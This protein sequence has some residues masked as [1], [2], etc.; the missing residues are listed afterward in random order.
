VAWLAVGAAWTGFAAAAPTPAPADA[1]VVRTSANYRVPA[2]PLVRADGAAVTLASELDYPGA[3]AL[4]FVFTSCSAICPIQSQTFADLQAR[5]RP[6]LRL[7]LISI[8]LDPLNDTPAALRDYARKFGAQ[9]QW[10][11]YTGAPDASI[12]AQRAFDVY[13]GNKMNHQPL[14]LLRRAPGQPWIRVEG[15]ADAATLLR[16]LEDGPEGAKIQSTR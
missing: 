2:V 15:Y 6:G 11:F 1:R 14:A 5:A 12:A 16:A 3:V 9:A 7:R 10:R 4:N 13:R 8:S